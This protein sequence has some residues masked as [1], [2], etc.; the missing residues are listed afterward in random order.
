MIEEANCCFFS[1]LVGRDERSFLLLVAI[2]RELVLEERPLLPGSSR[3]APEL[4]LLYR[5][6]AKRVKLVPRKGAIERALRS[7]FLFA[8]EIR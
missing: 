5:S 1:S 4:V 7:L 6:K 8:A 3:R 2:A